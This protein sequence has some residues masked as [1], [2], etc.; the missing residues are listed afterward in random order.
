MLLA[1]HLK[2]GFR[3]VLE[4]TGSLG[5]LSSAPLELLFIEHHRKTLVFSVL[6][7][8]GLQNVTYMAG[9]VLAKTFTVLK[10]RLTQETGHLVCGAAMPLEM[11]LEVGGAQKLGLTHVTNVVVVVLRGVV[12]FLMGQQLI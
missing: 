2:A 8:L 4:I 3:L 12:L 6:Q 1:I 11:G 10:V 7:M 5:M 9:E